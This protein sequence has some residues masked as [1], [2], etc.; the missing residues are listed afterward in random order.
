VTRDAGLSQARPISV[1]TFSTLYPNREMPHHGIFVENRLRS[2]L[3]SGEVAAMV[4][5]PVPW[6]P[7]AHEKFGHYPGRNGATRSPCCIRAMR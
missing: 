2:L 6:F 3:S 7:S 5:A 1:L 4:V